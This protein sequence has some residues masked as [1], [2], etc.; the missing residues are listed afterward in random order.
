MRLEPSKRGFFTVVGTSLALV[1]LF[2]AWPS[3]AGAGCSRYA[4]SNSHSGQLPQGLSVLE[5]GDR[6]NVSSEAPDRPVPCSGVFCSGK[7][8]VPAPTPVSVPIA[9][10]RLSEAVVIRSTI[11]P[12]PCDAGRYLACEERMVRAVTE[13][14]SIERPPR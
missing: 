11:P 13:G 7:P 14:F 2:C 9:V 6:G 10:G 4:V 3:K 5:H 12:T 8:A 1:M